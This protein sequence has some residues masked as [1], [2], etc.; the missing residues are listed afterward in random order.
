MDWLGLTG[1]FDFGF[2]P[3]D[4]THFEQVRILRPASH[5]VFDNNGYLI[6]NGRYFHWW[7]KPDWKRSYLDTIDEFGDIIGNVLTDCTYGSQIA[8]PIS[9]GLDSRTTVAVITR[10]DGLVTQNDHF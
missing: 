3:E 9:G 5:Y 10:P 4:R 8:I 7:Y 1:F 2:F 6:Q